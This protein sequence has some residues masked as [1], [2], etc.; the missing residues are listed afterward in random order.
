MYNGITISRKKIFIVFFVLAL[1]TLIW[2]ITQRTILNIKVTGQNDGDVSVFYTTDGEN[3]KKI[4]TGF[5][6]VKPGSAT[7]NISTDDKQSL[8]FQDV[9]V[10]WNNTASAQLS[11]QKKVSKVVGGIQSK[12]NCI[13]GDYSKIDTGIMS[14][15]NN[16]IYRQL[17][18]NGIEHTSVYPNQR[19]IGT[20]AAYKDG[21]LSI[22]D[23]TATNSVKYKLVYTTPTK[24]TV[25]DSGDTL[26][27]G[28]EGNPVLFTS[29]SKDSFA[30]LNPKLKTITLYK[31][32]GDQS[33]L[34]TTLNDEFSDFSFTD[35]AVSFDESSLVIAYP[36]GDPNSEDDVFGGSNLHVRLY[37]YT[38]SDTITERSNHTLQLGQIGGQ[39]QIDQDTLVLLGQDSY[40]HIFDISNN[41]VD[42]QASISRVDH[43]LVDRGNIF[44]TSQKA[45]YE[46]KKEEKKANLLRQL[47]EIN[48]AD[49]LLLQGR[50]VLVGNTNN[51]LSTFGAY[52]VLDQNKA[53]E[54]DLFTLIPYNTKVL[55]LIKSE[56]IGND[57][58]FSVDLK[59][60]I[61]ERDTG[62]I[63]YTNAEFEQ[64]KKIITEKLRSDGVDIQKYQL[65]F[66]PGP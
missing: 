41:K 56:Y 36:L 32:L 30:V 12:I 55:P 10:L 8:L 25:I 54:V 11:S 39:L 49:L 35:L 50:P 33:P 38:L 53:D 5:N 1:P 18:T 45:V 31:N 47:S 63:T 58:Y 9:R 40:L 29:S 61:F 48:E 46:Y 23:D 57:I 34:S 4:K 15:Q 28:D 66:N 60:I 64:K 19:I 14:C 43:I 52:A 62:R 24:Q 42:L 37:R 20:T 27:G 44:Y 7:I 3:P 51:S 16:H 65:H 22:V 2:L 17:T 26:R 6:I 21:Y 59:S 13:A